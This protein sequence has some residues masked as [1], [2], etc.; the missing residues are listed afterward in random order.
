MLD[1]QVVRDKADSMFPLNLRS[2]LLTAVDCITVCN[3][4]AQILSM[5]KSYMLTKCDRE[6]FDPLGVHTGDSIVIAPSQT[7]SDE[8]DTTK[9][10]TS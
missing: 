7:L 8:V 9:Y 2:K 1:A 5:T 6:N 3:M 4:Y 10:F